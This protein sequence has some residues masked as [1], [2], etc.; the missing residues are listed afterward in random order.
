M[1]G[2]ER[3]TLKRGTLERET[4]QRET[5]E[6]EVPE[7]EETLEKETT[8]ETEV[9]WWNSVHAQ[10]EEE[11]VK[12]IGMWVRAGKRVKGERG[13]GYG[14]IYIHILKLSST[15]SLCPPSPNPTPFPL[16]TSDER[17]CI[18][19]CFYCYLCDRYQEA[20][21]PCVAFFEDRPGQIT[22]DRDLNHPSRLC[23]SCEDLWT[24]IVERKG[25]RK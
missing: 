19:V 9:P 3:G 21:D 5:L 11:M 8:P 17:M 2:V 15:A 13:E 22:W 6:T 4:P 7:R 20:G 10:I 18:W 16:R 1:G 23:Q 12:E 14:H 24:A 25:K